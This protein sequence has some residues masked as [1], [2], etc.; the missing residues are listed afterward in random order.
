[1]GETPRQELP[2]SNLLVHATTVALG[3]NAALLRGPSGSGKSDLALRFIFGEP[4]HAN[5]QTEHRLVADD[6]T[7]LSLDTGRLFATAP[8]SITGLIEVR[9]V[10][11]ISV[12]TRPIAEVRLVIDLVSAHDVERLPDPDET[13]TMLGKAVPLRRLAAFEASAPLKL[14]LLL[15]ALV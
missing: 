13:V 14:R 12:P 6:Q 15:Q 11:I 1:M 2:G 4:M 7:H 10:G 5:A 8:V 9:G 3:T